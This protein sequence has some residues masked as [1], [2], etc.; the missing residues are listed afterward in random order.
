MV[1]IHHLFLPV[2]DAREVVTQKE[3]SPGKK[4]E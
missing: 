3:L 1:F 4:E 2:L